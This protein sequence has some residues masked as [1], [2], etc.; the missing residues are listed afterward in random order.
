M[1][2]YSLAFMVFSARL[3]ANWNAIMHSVSIQLRISFMV[4]VTLHAEYKGFWDMK[5]A[6][7]FVYV[8][9]WRSNSKPDKNQEETGIQMEET[10]WA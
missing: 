5:S 4:K 8:M 10:A 9:A 7:G 1:T 3:G 6:K 2:I